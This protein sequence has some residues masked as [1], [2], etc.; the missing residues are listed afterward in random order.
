MLPPQVADQH[1]NSGARIFPFQRLGGYHHVPQPL[2]VEPRRRQTPELQ[3]ES[4]LVI[5]VG[6]ERA[7]SD[8][9]DSGISPGVIR[10]VLEIPEVLPGLALVLGDRGGQGIPL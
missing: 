9:G 6:D 1:T 5:E 8:P 2:I 4:T 10:R 7:I 3:G